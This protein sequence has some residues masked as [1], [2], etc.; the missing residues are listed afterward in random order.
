MVTLT[1][2]PDFSRDELSRYSRQLLMPEWGP[3]GQKAVAAAKVVIIGVGGLG[4]PAARYLAAAGVGELLL[5]DDDEVSASNLHRQL[6][7]YP[8]DVGKPKAA[9][10]AARLGEQFPGCRLTAIAARAEPATI[11]ELVTGAQVVIDA[12]DNFSSRYLINDA[13]V[14]A[15]VPLCHASIGKFSGQASVFLPSG[16]CYRCLFPKP[17]PADAVAN[18]DVAGVIGVLPGTMALIQAT[19][20]LKLITGSGQPL[21][22]RVL[23]YDSMAMSFQSFALSPQ[24]DCPACA[25]AASPCP[26]PVQA[27]LTETRQAEPALADPS[28]SV[29]MNE[30]TPSQLRSRSDDVLIIDVRESAERQLIALEPCLAIPLPELLSGQRLS[31]LP[32]RRPIAV[33]CKTG[34]RAITAARYLY[35]QG[36]TEVLVVKGGIVA[37]ERGGDNNLAPI[38]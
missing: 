38:Y 4:C 16:P 22:G 20:A 17:P 12:T 15:G 1:T 34:T 8:A 28:S 32:Q 21:A 7:F 10:A 2:H 6:L 24:P 30:I 27:S 33:L 13:C 35:G 23:L 36:F 18:C 3:K 9:V 37:F 25:T 11:A 14:A 19:E 31:E 29:K 5:V 26:K